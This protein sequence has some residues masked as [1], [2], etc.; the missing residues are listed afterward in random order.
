ML[1]M[2]QWLHTYVASVCPQCFIYFFIC[3]L[4]AYL[5]GCCICFTHTVQVFY[6]DVVYVFNG[7]QLLLQVFQMHV[8]SVSFFIFVCCICCI[9]MFQSRSGVAHRMR[10]GSER[11][12]DRSPC[13]CHSG[14]RHGPCMSAGNARVVERRPGSVVPRVDA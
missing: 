1:H 10:V 4:Q 7:F 3:M 8:L 14:A 11:G 13:G 12:R 2:L 6:L 5:S 9:R